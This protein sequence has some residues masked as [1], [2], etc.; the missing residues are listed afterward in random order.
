MLRTK[1]GWGPCSFS[2]VSLARRP[3]GRG[4]AI[5]VR[6]EPGGE[7][8]PELGRGSLQCGWEASREPP[9][10]RGWEASPSRRGE[11]LPELGRAQGSL[12][13]GWEPET[14]KLLKQETLKLLGL[15]HRRGAA[16]RSGNGW[17]WSKL[18]RLRRREG[19]QEVGGGSGRLGFGR[20]R[21]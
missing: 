21:S 17:P 14:L 12:Q 3:T 20:S 18:S 4:A 1:P 6:G 15:R 11:P 5:W 16:R 13:C 10:L 2:F 19:E 9:P 8:L 7:P